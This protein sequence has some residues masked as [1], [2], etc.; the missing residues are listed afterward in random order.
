MLLT[1]LVTCME[2]VWLVP[3]FLHLILN[4][5]ILTILLKA[6]YTWRWVHV[7]ESVYGGVGCNVGYTTLMVE[8]FCVRAERFNGQ[9][10]SA[11]RRC[12]QLYLL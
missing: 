7:L 4:P 8:L 12:G 9:E 5:E 3:I 10:N 1:E 2:R 11:A 6:G